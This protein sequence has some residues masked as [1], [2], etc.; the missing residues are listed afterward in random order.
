MDLNP[1]RLKWGLFD[2][3]SRRRLAGGGYMEVKEYYCLEESAVYGMCYK[4][5]EAKVFTYR[6]AIYSLPQ[7]RTMGQEV[8]LVL[9]GAW[10]SFDASERILSDRSQEFIL[11]FDKL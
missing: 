6:I 9:K 11:R 5:G 7:W 1:E 8:G 4:E 3:P 2:E 10:G